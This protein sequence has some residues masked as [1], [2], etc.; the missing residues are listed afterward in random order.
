M[1]ENHGVFVTKLDTAVTPPIK[2]Y[3]GFPICFGTAPVHRTEDPANA[4]GKITI[5]YR[6][7]E[8]LTKLGYDDNWGY[9]DENKKWVPV[10]SCC[11][12]MFTQA[13]LYNVSPT[14]FVNV[15][16][17]AK[18][19]TQGDAQVLTFSKG[20]LTLPDIDAITGSIEIAKD[21]DASYTL[22][23]D[24][25]L[26][27][28]DDGL[29]VVTVLAGGELTAAQTVSVSYHIA[30]PSKVTKADIIAA[31]ELVDTCYPLLGLTP[32]LLLAPGWCDSEVGAVL[33]A[34]AQDVNRHF[35]AMAVLDISTVD[36]PTYE[37]AIAFKAANGL[38]SPYA[39]VCWPMVSLGGRVYNISTHA[40]GIC[41]KTDGSVEDVPS[42]SPSNEELQADG[43]CLANGKAIAL[44]P[45]QAE[46]VNSAGIVTAFR[47]GQ[48]G[49][50][51]WG[52]RTGAYP[53]S[54]DPVKSFIPIGRMFNYIKNTLTLTYWKKI[55]SRMGRPLID[56]IVTS[57]NIWLAGL[58]RDG[59]I[60]GGRVVYDPDENPVTDL[61]NGKIVFHVYV[62]PPPPAQEIRFRLEFDV[63]YLSK[64]AA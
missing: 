41:I 62:T 5:A 20:I 63:D 19:F 30:D 37:T 47:L 15:F 58:A 10:W 50:V 46:L 34:K 60:I 16:D 53:G 26:A 25:T 35:D 43:A 12:L 33:S 7:N 61:M 39:I 1:A 48:E 59:H 44:G 32:G 14:G 28:D 22:G 2:A 55:D 17:P 3:A 52:N 42:V 31:T 49:W 56:N 29:V 54:S 4:V 23:T 64:M 13:K 18:H 11:E 21:N 51:L 9:L 38:V 8:M 57:A 6:W 45:D 36:A 24:Y 27:R 40:V